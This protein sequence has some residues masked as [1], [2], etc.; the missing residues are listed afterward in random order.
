MSAGRRIAHKLAVLGAVAACLGCSAAPAAATGGIAPS[1]DSEAAASLSPFE[2]LVE[3]SI[4]ANGEDTT[5]KV[6][7]GTSSSYGAQ[8]P[9]EPADIGGGLSD[10]LAVAR[11]PGLAANTTYFYRVSVENETGASNG[12]GGEL[13][14]PIAEG[15]AVFAESATSTVPGKATLEA[16]INPNFQETSY[17]FEYATNEAL[18]GAVIVGAGSLYGGSEGRRIGPVEVTGLET[19]VTYYFRAVV[20]NATGVAEGPVQSFKTIG[21]PRVEAAAVQ[22]TGRTTAVL[23]GTVDPEGGAS[24]YRFLYIDQAGYEAALASAAAN[25]YAKGGSSSEE[26]L[27]AGHEAEDTARVTLEELRPGTVYHY[28]LLATNSVG[29]RLGADG[30]FTTAPPAPPGAV[31]QGVT[32]IDLTDAVLAG[33]VDSRGLPTS[34]QFELGTEAGSYF[35][36]GVE[37]ASSSAAAEVSWQL[38]YLAPGVTYHYRLC[39]TNPDGTVCG[40]D[41]TFATAGVTSSVPVPSSVTPLPIPL[42]VSAPSVSEPHPRALRKAQKLARALK[43]CRQKPAKRRASCQRQARKRYGGLKSH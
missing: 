10:Q 32:G 35:P 20:E 26:S 7:Y 12:A 40:A 16:F 34:F 38:R 39:A 15:P 4:N 22:G 17:R 23:S 33:S 24:S 9:C 14:T 27:P 36:Q 3:A 21:P 30:T 25:P 29:A 18:V 11:L 43:L 5:C 2:V 28:A 19:G 1:I 6:E 31:T 8:V 13:T 41:Q 37:A 42:P